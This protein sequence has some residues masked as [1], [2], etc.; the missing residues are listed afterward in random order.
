[1]NN[2]ADWG[3]CSNCGACMNA[4]PADAIYLDKDNLFYTVKVDEKKCVNCGKCTQVCPTI[5]NRE[6]KMPLSAWWGYALNKQT[7]KH[8]SSGGI[9]SAV[10][11][12][13]LRENGI[14]YGAAFSD[15]CKEVVMTSSDYVSLDAL[16][17]SKYVESLVGY[18]FRSVRKEL[19]TG[20]LVLYCGTPC[21]I[22]GLINFLG[23]DYPNLYT[24]DFACGGLSSHIIYQDHLRS[25]E[26]RY[27]SKVKSVNFRS[28][29]YGWSIY[30][31]SIHFGNGK[32]Y[33]VPGV[34]DPYLCGFLKE[35]VNVRDYCYE[36]KFAAHHVSDLILA[37]FWKFKEIVGQKH[38]NTGISLVIANSEKGQ[39]LLNQ[40]MSALALSEVA[41]DQAGYN[42]HSPDYPLSLM[43]LRK[44]YLEEFEQSGI[45][46]AAKVLKKP[47]GF[48]AE[49]IRIKCMLRGIINRFK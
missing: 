19:E 48:A 28:K 47:E 6:K 3:K 12:Y 41:L 5:Q 8:S 31:L 17:R 20:R 10:A 22:A 16:R 14:V 36:C 29:K 15:N 33:E 37:D 21:Q 9:F 25:L 1:M 44:K 35:H 39:Y 49:K 38:D 43:E 45:L 7:V 11:G 18:S 42:L 27:N 4:C 34:L 46:Q 30:S 24:C 32:K 40:V 2:I 23:T 26:E 13:I